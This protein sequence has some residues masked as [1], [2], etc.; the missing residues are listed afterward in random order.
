MKELWPPNA[1]RNSELDPGSGGRH[2]WG[3][4]DSLN[5]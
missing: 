3:V 1:T 5:N 4:Q 2:L